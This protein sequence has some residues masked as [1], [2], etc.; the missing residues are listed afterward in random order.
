[1]GGLIARLESAV[2]DL[3]RYQQTQGDAGASSAPRATNQPARSTANST[4]TGAKVQ[5]VQLVTGEDGVFPVANRNI[6]AIKN[7]GKIVDSTS[8]YNKDLQ[9]GPNKL[10]DGEVW[11]EVDAKGSFGWASE[12]FTPGKEYVTIGFANDRTHL[13]GRVTLNPASNQ[14][15]LR[16]ARRIQ[17]DV[18]TGDLKNGPWKTAAII[19][20]TPRTVNQDF[21]IRP[22]EAKYVRF[23]FL[24][25][26][27]GVTLPNADPNVNSDRAVSLG[28]IEIYE[29]VAGND[30][31]AS[32]VGRFNQVLVDLKTLRRRGTATA[33]ADDLITPATFV[34]RAKTAATAVKSSVKPAK[35]NAVEA[36]LNRPA[37][38]G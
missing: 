10:I 8:F 30:Q 9:Y 7:G 15:D 32:L 37:R 38:N 6:A 23:I 22:V 36:S 25:N 14:S 28:E 5:N 21:T 16:F 20:L 2:S 26:G 12:G 34:P 35:K 18:T 29:A 3:R 13:V 27:P 31:L 19:N 11:R 4:S 17:M 24:A 1:M 33:P